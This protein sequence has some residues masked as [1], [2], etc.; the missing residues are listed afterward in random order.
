VT[1]DVINASGVTGLATETSNLLS[2][3]GYEAETVGDPKPGETT[4]AVDYGP[5][6]GEAAQTIATMLGIVTP[7]REQRD[8]STGFVRVVLGDGY[9]LPADITSLATAPTGGESLGID[10]GTSSSSSS[11]SSDTPAPDQGLPIS[12]SGVPCV[13]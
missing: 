13:N 2:H 4:S 9:D 6:A 10:V 12:G 5:G 11:A 7:P 1:V 3:N 8:L